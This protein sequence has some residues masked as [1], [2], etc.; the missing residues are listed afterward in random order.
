MAPVRSTSRSTGTI[1]PAAPS[2]T[3]NSRSSLRARSRRIPRPPWPSRRRRA[4]R[5][6]AATT[7]RVT[8]A[9]GVSPSGLSMSLPSDARPRAAGRRR[10]RADVLAGSSTA[11]NAPRAATASGAERQRLDRATSPPGPARRRRRGS[12]PPRRAARVRPSLRAA[13]GPPRAWRAHDRTT[14]GSPCETSRT[15]A[16]TE[17]SALASSTTTHWTAEGSVERRPQRGLDRP[18][19]VAARDHDRDR[20]SAPPR[21]ALLPHASIRCRRH[22]I[23]GVARA[24]RSRG[25]DGRRRA[26]SA[27]RVRWT[28][29]SHSPVPAST[30]M[31]YVVRWVGQ[32]RAPPRTP[33]GDEPCRPVSRRRPWGSR[34]YT[35]IEPSDPEKN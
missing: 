12:R 2:R 23:T 4:T 6:A 8:S 7:S 31:K 11:R 28:C 25:A 3:S 34:T 18:C 24:A 16:P 20:P 13:A 19:G 17:P 26:S 15:V 29:S 1:D 30:S 32:G 21:R 35:R 33:G 9:S 22:P 10:P 5:R 27:V 14:R